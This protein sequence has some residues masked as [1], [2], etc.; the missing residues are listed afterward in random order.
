MFSTINEWQQLETVIDFVISINTVLKNLDDIFTVRSMFGTGIYD[1]FRDY[2]KSEE[3]ISRG[4]LLN[5]KISFQK[6][7]NFPSL[8]ASA[9]S[10]VFNLSSFS[11][12]NC[13]SS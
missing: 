12:S 9:C 2:L 6:V 5:T 8:P 1:V 7:G 11:H 3:D 13:C 4:D 10:F